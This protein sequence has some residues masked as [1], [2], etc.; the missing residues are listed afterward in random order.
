[1]QTTHTPGLGPLQ[2]RFGV[3]YLLDSPPPAERGVVPAGSD[4]H[5]VAMLSAYRRS[6][7]LARADEVVTLLDRR[8]LPGVATLARW[9]VERRVISFEWQL[10][11]WL[12]WFQF[13]RLEQVPDPAVAALFSESTAVCDGWELAQWFARPH[14]ALSGHAPVDLVTSDPDAVLQA[15]RADRFAAQ[16]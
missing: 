15:A 13:K 11:T 2:P 4:R 3:G 7:G 9:I 10:Q 5:F 6:G 14:P 12:P 8:G 1:M 16:G